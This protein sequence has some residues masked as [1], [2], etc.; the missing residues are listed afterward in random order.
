MFARIRSP[1]MIAA[2]L[3]LALGAA[4][5]KRDPLADEA[6]AD[7]NA[8]RSYLMT[9]MPTVLDDIECQ[10]CAKSLSLCYQETLGDKRPSCPDT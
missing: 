4:C 5:D 6:P 8:F 2:L 7:P 10:C 9:R 3:A 1:V